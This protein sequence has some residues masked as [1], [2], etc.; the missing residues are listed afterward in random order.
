MDTQSPDERSNVGQAFQP[1]ASTGGK[2]SLLLWLAMCPAAALALA[3]LAA[4]VQQMYAPLVLFSLMLG[5][6][7]GASIVALGKACGVRSRAAVL[8]CAALC[9]LPAVA[10]EH[11][12]G[13][14]DYRKAY[15]TTARREPRWQLLRGLEGEVAPVGFRE[16]LEAQAT[17]GRPWFG[18]TR[19]G[20]MVWI[21]WGIDGLL[22]V[23][24]AYVVARYLLRPG[25]Q[26]PAPAE[27]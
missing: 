2:A 25:K 26:S 3:F 6:A 9:A 11:Y 24:G 5:L 19:Y 22:V 1:D 8:W 4:R 23:G 21:T 12:F 16:F 14:L 10:G 27:H 7:V 13:Y 20:G 15:E 17:R 18:R